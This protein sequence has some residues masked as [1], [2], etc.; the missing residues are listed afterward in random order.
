MRIMKVM[1]VA[2]LLAS[3]VGVAQAEDGMER[4]QRFQA[5]FKAEQERLW[6]DGKEQVVKQDKEDKKTDS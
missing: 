5:Q 1:L 2:G 4:I 3:S 6:G